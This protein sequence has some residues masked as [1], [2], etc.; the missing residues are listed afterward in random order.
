[1][2][3]NVGRRSSELVFVDFEGKQ[4]QEYVV[5]YPYP[6]V[7]RVLKFLSKSMAKLKRTAKKSGWNLV[8]VGVTIP[9]QLW[10]WLEIVGAPQAAMDQWRTFNFSE[11]V[12]EKTGLEVFEENDATA[13]CIAEHL[14]GY[15]K[16]YSDF[17]YFFVGAFVGG[18]LVLDDKIFSGRYKGAAAFGS[19]PMRGADGK[20]SQLL[21]LASI[22][23]LEGRLK[24]EGIDP[25]VIRENLNDWTQIQEHV[26]VWADEAG[27]HL[28]IASA[29]I[30]SVV[31][32]Q[33]ILIDGALPSTTRATIC[34][35]ASKHLANMDLDGIVRPTIQE[36]TVGRAARSTGAALL[37]IHAKYFLI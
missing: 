34:S 29:T 12:A 28:A 32:I 18:G 16:D 27:R 17:G 5:T 3:F 7:D 36:A 33:S 31:E 35:A 23:S 37:P 10:G 8:G 9:N 14:L 13:A 15:G 4:I 24:A 2:G 11:A 19:I 20:L 25:N 21:S 6:T 22:Y 1:L 26:D 30:A